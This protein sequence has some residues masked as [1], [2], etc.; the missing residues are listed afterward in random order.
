M[1]VEAQ[2]IRAY[3]NPL[4]SLNVWPKVKPL[5]LGGVRGRGGWLNSHDLTIVAWMSRCPEVRLDQR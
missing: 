2:G 1:V 5:L 3:E 4:V